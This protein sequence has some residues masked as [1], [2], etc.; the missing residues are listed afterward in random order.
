MQHRQTPQNK[1][2]ISVAFFDNWLLSAENL[3]EVCFEPSKLE[4]HA[5]TCS[6]IAESRRNYSKLEQF[7]VLFSTCSW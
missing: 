5:G 7:Q 2:I 1:S 3:C 6:I 4:K